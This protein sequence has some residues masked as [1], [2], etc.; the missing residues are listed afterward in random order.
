MPHKSKSSKNYK[1]RSGHRK[2]ATSGT[3]GVVT[4]SKKQSQALK[5]KLKQVTVRPGSGPRRTSTTGLSPRARAKARKTLRTT[6][7]KS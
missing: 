6:R 7:R 3:F 2:R 5:K 1:S 4:P